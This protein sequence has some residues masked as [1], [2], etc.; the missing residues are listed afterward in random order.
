M[1]NGVIRGALSLQGLRFVANKNKNRI[2]Q[3]QI[4]NFLLWFIAEFQAVVLAIVAGLPQNAL[5]PELLRAGCFFIG[6]WQLAIRL[7]KND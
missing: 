3:F 4:S 7:P 5:P 2:S 1:E 6:D